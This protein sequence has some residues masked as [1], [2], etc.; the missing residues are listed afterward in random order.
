MI[1]SSSSLSEKEPF[2]NRI[3]LV[4]FRH[5]EKGETPQEGDEKTPLTK[6]GIEHAYHTA[7][8]LPNPQR[9]ISSQRDRVKHTAVI[10]LAKA[11]SLSLEEI[12]KKTLEE[13]IREA[14]ESLK[15]KQPEHRKS[16]DQ[17]DQREPMIRKMVHED[18]RL[19]F[20]Y[21]SDELFGAAFYKVYAQKPNNQTLLWQVQQSDNLVLRLAKEK[22]NRGLMKVSTYTRFAGDMAEMIYRYF[23]AIGK[24]REIRVQPKLES[25]HE[26]FDLNILM[27]THSQNLE[28][29]L[30]RL[31]EI[32]E[33]QD[34][35]SDFLHSLPDGKS[36]VGF[37]EGMS[38]D[39]TE[40][41]TRIE[42][43]KEITISFRDKEWKVSPE[44]L[45]RMIQDRNDYN[46]SVK[47]ELKIRANLDGM[48]RREKLQARREAQEID[49]D[50]FD[51]I[52]WL[53][54]SGG[55]PLTK[56]DLG[57]K[58]VVLTLQE[59]N[60]IGVLT[61]LSPSGHEL[62]LDADDFPD[63]GVLIMYPED[64]G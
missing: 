30:M 34:K 58:A 55:E 37:S 23:R 7:T 1:E 62:N 52:S 21:E 36:F 29:F 49:N 41:Q 6:G 10:K 26:N 15:L 28:C 56:E 3:H 2:R 27:G 11:Q 18:D 54:H 8:A 33:G 16:P 19:N 20:D 35:L 59:F 25:T 22:Y 32:K 12:E 38:V 46:E 64:L 47:S 39:I 63:G 4:I 43:Q 61:I 50:D 53:N 13:L 5:D 45:R 42:P 48:D 51:I 57:S 9:I 17:P 44:D 24:L 60:D 31:I 40:H 14:N